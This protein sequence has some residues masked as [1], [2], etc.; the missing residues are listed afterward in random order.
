MNDRVIDNGKKEGKKKR[1]RKGRWKKRREIFRSCNSPPPRSFSTVVINYRQLIETI[2]TGEIVRGKS[3]GLSYS[4][5]R[6]FRDTSA[7]REELIA[8]LL[9][10]HRRGALAASPLTRTISARDRGIAPASN[11]GFLRDCNSASYRFGR[12]KNASWRSAI[13]IAER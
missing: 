11:R 12:W 13:K 7:F 9:P 6:A 3:R 5:A 1:T 4:E 10:R 8:R 2:T